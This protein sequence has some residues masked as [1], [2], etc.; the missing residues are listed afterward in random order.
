M[1]LTT[2]TQ[3]LT[4]IAAL[5]LFLWSHCP[6]PQLSRPGQTAEDV[7]RESQQQASWASAPPGPSAA[8][9]R[10]LTPPAWRSYPFST[11]DIPDSSNLLKPRSPGHL[12]QL[13][14]L[15]NTE[16]QRGCSEVLAAS[17]PYLSPYL[18]GQRGHVPSTVHRTWFQALFPPCEFLLLKTPTAPVLSAS[19]PGSV[20][21]QLS[22]WLFRRPSQSPPQ[23][24][25][26][27]TCVLQSWDR[28]RR[29]AHSPTNCD[30]CPPHNTTHFLVSVVSFLSP[31]TR[32]KSVSLLFWWLW[33]IVIFLVPSWTF[34]SFFIPRTLVSSLGWAHPVTWFQSSARWWVPDLVF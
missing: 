20:G 14:T 15:R 25:D 9:P 33:L 6:N 23:R 1:T 10:L 12:I 31:S 7:W 17:G 30:L 28:G 32:L 34:S 11:A 2:I 5:E 29:R 27:V 8:A 21:F 22:T 24:L 16:A 3:V 4:A 18:V 13:L 19:Y 26:C